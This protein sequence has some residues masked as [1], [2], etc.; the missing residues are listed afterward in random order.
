MPGKTIWFTGRFCFLTAFWEV[1]YERKDSKRAAPF[2][3]RAAGIRPGELLLEIDGNGIEDFLDY[4]FF[5]ASENVNLL[6]RSEKGEE[7]KVHIRK[8]EYEDLGLEFGS[9]L[10][11][12]QRSCRNQCIFC[13][14]D[15]M[16]PGCGR[17]FTLRTT[18]RG[19][20]S[21]TATISP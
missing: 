5:M 15:Q 10:M 20:A 14:I 7:R 9:D 13:F 21:S 19:S 2:P 6:L 16:P 3:R 4:R 12:E 8:G 11:D 17:P 18:T 1:Y